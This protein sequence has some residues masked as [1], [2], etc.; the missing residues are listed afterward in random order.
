MAHRFYPIMVEE[1]LV[2]RCPKCRGHITKG[3]V[4]MVVGVDGRVTSY[5]PE[6]DTEKDCCVDIGTVPKLFSSMDAAETFI[7]MLESDK[8]A[9]LDVSP[10]DY[11]VTYL[12]EVCIKFDVAEI[13]RKI[14]EAE[15]NLDSQEGPVDIVVGE[16]EA[17]EDD[18][19]TGSADVGL[20]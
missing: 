20:N 12:K 9:V 10:I 5:V 19:K 11:L 3:N 1:D 8:N 15:K 13:N 16:D 7:L 14:A 6:D 18:L 17:F 2:V 4:I